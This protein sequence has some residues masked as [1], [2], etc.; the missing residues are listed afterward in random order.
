[1][2]CAFSKETNCQDLSTD[3][4]YVNAVND[5]IFLIDKR[6]DNPLHFINS[7]YY[8]SEDGKKFDRARK[9]AHQYTRAV[10]KERKDEIDPSNG[11]QLLLEQ[12]PKG[13]KYHDLLDILLLAR[14]EDGNGLKDQ[15]I[16]DEVDTFMS[17][18]H[19]MGSSLSAILYCLALHP[20]HQDKIREEA[21]SI[22]MGKEWM[23]YDD[24]KEL[25]YTTWC[26]K[27]AR[28]L[29]QSPRQCASP[30]KTPK[31]TVTWSPRAP[32]LYWISCR[33]TTTQ[34]LGTAPTNITLSVFIL[35]TPKRDT[36]MLTSLSLLVGTTV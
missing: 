1:M 8:H 25:K 16:R 19:T 11:G 24:L 20:E 36:H 22:L 34:T 29:Y 14:D 3:H 28:R 15:E 12:L 32:W 26:I 2:Q 18:H 21:R 7:I 17:A 35:T 6:L 31:W 9:A 4:I 13:R 10:V 33:F 23:E 30:Q 27:E 5:L